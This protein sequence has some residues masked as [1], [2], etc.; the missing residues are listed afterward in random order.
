MT[1]MKPFLPE[2]NKD[3]VNHYPNGG[4]LYGL[5]LIY[6][7]SCDK[8]VI[9]Y[10][11][12]VTRHADHSKNDVVM[13]GSCLGLG[14][15]AFASENN[16]I[17]ERLNDFMN[18]SSSVIG[19]AAGLSLGLVFAGTANEAILG[20]LLNY[21]EETDHEKVLRS[22]CMSIGILNFG[23]PS[24]EILSNLEGNPKVK[25]S[26]PMYIAMAYFKTS[27]HEAVRKLLNCTNDISNEVK[28]S[29]V[30]ALGFVMYHD[31]HLIELMK[32][33]IYSYNPSIRYACAMA[34]MVGCKETKDALDLIWPLLTDAVD[35]VRQAA[36]ISI[37]IIM[38]VSTVQS[39]PRLADF[40]KIVSETMAKKHEETLSKMGAILANGLL[41]IGGRNMVVSL[42][43]RAGVPKIQS[44]VYMLVFTHFWNWF[45]YINFIGLTLTVSAFI[46]VTAKLRIPTSFTFKSACKSS[47]FDYPPNIVKEEKKE[48]TKKDTKVTLS[49]TVKFNARAKNKKSGKDDLD[50]EPSLSH[51]VSLRN[52]TSVGLPSVVPAAPAAQ[53]NLGHHSLSMPPEIE[54]NVSIIKEKK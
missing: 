53:P 10:I 40:R 18:I 17:K 6:A 2:S 25:L 41:D 15:T 30:I 50:S 52:Q 32:M 7:G 39:E 31:P 20:E 1:P 28:R 35:Y 46:G 22:I 24:K 49:T 43:T 42:T 34:L 5:G 9:D 38:Q 26:V 54:S 19:E 27:N 14:L 21:A 13:H 44:V 37:S 36:F 16:D 45:P 23:K 12:G 11:M 47:M 29:A 4:A 8:A 51:Q 3:V 48:E 33:M